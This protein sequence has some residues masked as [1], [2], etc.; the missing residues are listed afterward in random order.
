LCVAGQL[1]DTCVEGAPEAADDTS[2]DGVDQDCSGQ[3]DEEYAPVATACGVGV[4]V[5]AGVTSC[6]LGDVE[7]SCVPGA[8]QA[9]DDTS[10]DATDQDCSGQN[11]EDYVTTPTS[12]GVGGCARTGAI[13][14][15]LGVAADNC[16]A[17]TPAASD[18]TCDGVDDDCDNSADEEFTPALSNCG[19]GVC[20]SSGMTSCSAG[21]PGD[22]CV[23]GA[24]TSASDTTCNAL[25]EDC[26]GEDDEDYVTTPT[27]CTVGGCPATGAISCIAGNVEDTCA[28]APDD[29]TCDGIDDD[30]D[31]ETDEDAVCTDGG[32]GLDDASAPGSEPGASNADD[33]ATASA[34]NANDEAGTD[35]AGSNSGGTSNGGPADASG[36]GSSDPDDPGSSP[37]IEAGL[38]GPRRGVAPGSKGCSCTLPGEQREG[39]ALPTSLLL[40]L[41]T[42]GARR[43]VLPPRIAS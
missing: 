23:P 1:D 34:G 25:D 10:C 4:C 2:C 16:T 8:P 39:A 30:C 19:Q 36:N 17:G 12:C 13:V 9:A 6:V 20:A 35:Q 43:K 26:D 42:L 41:L 38:D 11:D 7:D 27:T 40:M 28:P 31:G 14:C 24:S 29:Q 5:A 37:E 21:V 22:S 33:A 32:A 18:T 3:N 15:T